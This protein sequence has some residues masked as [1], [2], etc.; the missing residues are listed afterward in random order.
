MPG[1]IVF[2]D[3]LHRRFRV[4]V[5]TVSRDLGDDLVSFAP[6]TERGGGMTQESCDDGS[7]D[8]GNDGTPLR[9]LNWE[10]Y[11]VVTRAA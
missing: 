5:Q 1:G 10:H 7:Y 9:S 3:L 11:A 8:C 6:P 2:E 4:R